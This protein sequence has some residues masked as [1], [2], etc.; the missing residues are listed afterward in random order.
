[1]N[2][3]KTL[4]DRMLA[5]SAFDPRWITFEQIAESGAPTDEKGKLQAARIDAIVSAYIKPRVMA[6][7][8]PER[9]EVKADVEFLL[10]VAQRLDGLLSRERAQN[11]RLSSNLQAAAQYIGELETKLSQFIA[12]EPTK[13]IEVVSEREARAEIHAR[14]RYIEP[15][16][17]RGP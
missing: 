4:V 14:K 15:L 2:Q 11:Q 1:M 16:T 10:K 7:S 12:P 8:R 17:K 3:K 5:D 13:G 6:S 9:T